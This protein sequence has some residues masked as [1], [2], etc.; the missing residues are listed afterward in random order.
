[1]TRASQTK[2]SSQTFA[3]ASTQMQEEWIDLLKLYTEDSS[4]LR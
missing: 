2:V 3:A 4:N 1:M